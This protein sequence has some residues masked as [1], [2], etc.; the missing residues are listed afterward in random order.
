[1]LGNLEVLVRAKGAAKQRADCSPSECCQQ[2]QKQQ[3]QKSGKETDGQRQLW[4]ALKGFQMLGEG[5]AGVCGP[6]WE[7]QRSTQLI[8]S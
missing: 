1:M 6:Q 4:M 3:Q 7:S 5:P 2:Q 8:Q